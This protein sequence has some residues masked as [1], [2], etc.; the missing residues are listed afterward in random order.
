MIW[1]FINSS[2]KLHH[3]FFFLVLFIYAVV[4]LTIPAVIWAATL[5]SYLS[6]LTDVLFIL[7]MPFVFTTL[8]WFVMAMDKDRDLND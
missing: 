8:I 3:R 7:V 6:I 5:V 4:I 1:S 2:M